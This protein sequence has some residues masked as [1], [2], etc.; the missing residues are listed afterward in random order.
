MGASPAP[1]AGALGR[2]RK[3]LGS[4]RDMFLSKMPGSRAPPELVLAPHLRNLGARESSAATSAAASPDVSNTEGGVAEVAGVRE[5][6]LAAVSAAVGHAGG[7]GGVD[8]SEGPPKG[9]AEMEVQVASESVVSRSRSAS[10]Q[11]LV[12]APSPR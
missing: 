3:S 12:D 11:R 7:D 5:R 2:R 8:A 9:S 1:D 4:G 6:A 10:L